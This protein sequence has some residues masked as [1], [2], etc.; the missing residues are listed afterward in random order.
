M[1]RDRVRGGALTPLPPPAPAVPLPPLSAPES[2][3]SLEVG[4]WERWRCE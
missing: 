2:L 4:M 3:E 1:E